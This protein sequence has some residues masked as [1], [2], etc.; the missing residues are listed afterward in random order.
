MKVTGFDLYRFRLPLTGPLVLRGATLTH[1]EGL[2]LRL[3]GEGGASGWGEA[4]PLPGFSPESLPDAASGLRSLAASIVGQGLTDEWIG[5]DGEL[6]LLLDSIELAPSVRFGLELAA[7]NLY[8][9]SIDAA[10]PA[11]ISPGYRPTVPVNGLLAGSSEEVLE[12]ARRMRD[13]GYEAVKLKVGK[14]TVVQDA[15]LVRAVK[16]ALG[17]GV[18][19]RLDAN[20]AWSLAEARAFIRSVEGLRIE[21]I[22]EPLADPAGL[23]EFAQESSIP[24]AL[25]ESLVGMEPESLVEHRYTGAVVIKPS[26]LGG[27]S[28]VMRLAERAV[29]LGM[30][31]VISSAYETGVGTSALLALAA[32]VGDEEIPAGLDTYRRLASDVIEPR[33]PLPAPRLRTR[34]ATSWREIVGDRLSPEVEPTG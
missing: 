33:L 3:E 34:E 30:R 13:A 25:D 7:W 8:A 24:V 29:S 23:G 2:L 26:L 14:G 27:I 11:V 5:A 21:Y 10:L 28:R 17:E 15:G 9:A 20:R 12:G 6:A 1:R 31:P 4:S 16:E 19:L 22:E 18:S 32:A